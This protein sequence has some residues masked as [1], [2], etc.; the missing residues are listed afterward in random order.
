MGIRAE[1]YPGDVERVAQ[2]VVASIG[3]AEERGDPF[4]HLRLADVFPADVYAAM[5][6]SMPGAE[7]YRP[8][9]GR[10]R[11]SRAPDGS[12]TRTK[13]DLFPEFVRHLPPDS[14][15]VWGTVG[16]ALCDAQVREAFRGRFAGALEKR[17]GAA[18]GSAG[19]YPIPILTRDVA[20]YRIGIHPDTRRKAITVQLYLPADRSVEHIGT[21]FHRRGGDGGYERAS[22][23]PFAPNTG[24][25]FAVGSDTYHSVD[26]VGPEVRTR[27]SILLTYFADQTWIEVVRN[28]AKRLGNLVLNELRALAR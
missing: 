21:V 24:Y 15:S 10:A 9:S 11:E 8:M 3:R 26:T 5:M 28:R 25:A 19:L 16:R 27:D 18:H 13:L 17:F 2:Q 6:R 14:R 23:M 12:P 1:A 20:G 22:K 7:G 4:H